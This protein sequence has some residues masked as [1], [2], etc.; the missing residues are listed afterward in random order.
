MIDITRDVTRA[1]QVGFRSVRTYGWPF[2]FLA[3]VESRILRSWQIALWLTPR[4]QINLSLQTAT[5]E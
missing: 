5:N 4:W 1:A 3:I 2:L